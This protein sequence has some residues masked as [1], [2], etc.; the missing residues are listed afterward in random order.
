MPTSSLRV[1]DVMVTFTELMSVSWSENV[2]VIYFVRPHLTIILFLFTYLPHGRFTCRRTAHD[3][4]AAIFS[5]ELPVPVTVALSRE[6]FL[7][8]LPAWVSQLPQNKKKKLESI[9]EKKSSRVPGLLLGV[10]TSV[11]LTE[12]EASKLA[13]F[14]RKQ[15]KRSAIVVYQE[16]GSK[17][18]INLF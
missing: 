8:H 9:W 7:V 1:L 13:L 12:V 10:P 17:N 14:A 2:L 5:R 6:G 15:S 4:P 18:I 16:S 3:A 11:V